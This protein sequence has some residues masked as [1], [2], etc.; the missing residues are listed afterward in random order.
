MSIALTHRRFGGKSS[1]ED[2]TEEHPFLIKNAA[3]FIAFKQEIA[4][5]NIFDGI[6]H[7][8]VNDIDLNY[9][10]IPYS[11]TE[12]YYGFLDGNHKTLKNIYI[13]GVDNTLIRYVQRDI[14]CLRLTNV[15][16]NST[17]PPNNPMVGIVCYAL[18]GTLDRISVDGTFT[19]TGNGGGLVASTL[20]FGCVTNCYTNV[21]MSMTN[22][23]SGGIMGRAYSSGVAGDRRI[24]NSIAVGNVISVQG[25]ACGI[26]GYQDLAMTIRN[27]VAAMNILQTKNTTANRITGRLLGTYINN[28]ALDSMLVK[29]ATVSN[30]TTINANGANATESQLKSTSFYRDVL[31]WDMDTIWEIETEGVTF[32]RL[33]GFN[34]NF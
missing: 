34:Y 28:Y 24:E 8:I 25:E 33:R 7:K 12:D 9:S 29:G 3:D 27:C 16:L 13:N 4:D 14:K 20:P 26:I 1:I 11:S 2:G 19:S 6:Y 30:G 15:I 10:Q 21:D 18:G 32:P 22:Y 17:A 23:P 5:G 31:G